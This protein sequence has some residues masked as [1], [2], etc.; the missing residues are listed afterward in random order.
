MGKKLGIPNRGKE[1][2]RQLGVGQRKYLN[3]HEWRINMQEA[4]FRCVSSHWLHIIH[5]LSWS[6]VVD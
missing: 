2:E 5:F 1:F 3:L 4:V 6:A